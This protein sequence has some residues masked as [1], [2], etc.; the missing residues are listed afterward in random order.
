MKTHSC[1]CFSS[2]LKL[3]GIICYLLVGVF[4]IYGARELQ[5]NFEVTVLERIRLILQVTV[6]TFVSVQQI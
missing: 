2:N 1:R 4:V 3:R 5:A 6:S